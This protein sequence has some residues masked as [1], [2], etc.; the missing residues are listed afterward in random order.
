MLEI[1]YQSVMRLTRRILNQTLNAINAIMNGIPGVKQFIRLALLVVVAQQQN[2]IVF[3][4]FII[5]YN[6][7]FARE[8]SY[9]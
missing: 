7:F 6:L 2:A 3:N 8:C 1:K 5:K 9:G 4:K